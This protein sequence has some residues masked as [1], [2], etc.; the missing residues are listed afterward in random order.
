MAQIT[1]ADVKKLREMTSAGMMDCKRALSETDGDMD[2]AV[3]FL[4]KKGL[5]AAAKKAGRVA[6]EGIVLATSTGN[7]G[8]ILEVNSE[9]DFVSKNE[10]FREFVDHLAKLIL[11]KNPADVD[12]L[13]ALS[14]DGEHSVKQALSRLISTIGENMSIRRFD[15]IQLGH[16]VVSSYVHGAGK[17]GVLIGIKGK[18]DQSLIDIARG[19]AM[20]VAAVNPRHIRREEVPSDA[21]ERER[22]VLSERAAASGKPEHIIDKIVHGQ[23]NKFYSEICL[24]DQ[25]FVM[26]TDHTV[27][28]ALAAVQPDSEVV[29][30]RRFQLGEGIEKEE[31]DFAA[32]VAAQVNG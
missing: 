7:S 20:H 21:I 24:L 17:I 9:T 29:L 32:E 11:N 31:S 19:I 15:R 26:D 16:G 5:A 4:R 12:A 3:D 2:A 1:A 23:L 13:N 27:A 25:E 18:E 28:G 8:V 22:S 14:F 30:M 10:Q 6:A